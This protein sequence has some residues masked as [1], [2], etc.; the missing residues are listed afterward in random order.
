MTTSIPYAIGLLRS[1]DDQL[2]HAGERV[3]RLMGYTNDDDVMG[4][5]P[6]GSDN[7][8]SGGRK[9]SNHIPS[10]PPPKR[11]ET[12]WTHMSGTDADQTALKVQLPTGDA[13][14]RPLLSSSP[15]GGLIRDL[16]LL[17]LFCHLP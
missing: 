10:P 6:Q 4:C 17:I 16:I 8:R 3:F 11:E 13:F 1:G 9:G 12:G 7:Q 15:A 2:A 5:W 14:F